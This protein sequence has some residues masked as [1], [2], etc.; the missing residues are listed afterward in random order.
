M[1][2]IGGESDEDEYSLLQNLKENYLFSYCHHLIEYN[3]CNFWVH[4][5]LTGFELFCLVSYLLFASTSYLSSTSGVLDMEI[6]PQLP[7]T[8]SIPYACV[9][10]Y[11]AAVGSLTLLTAGFFLQRFVKETDNKCSGKVAGL[12]LKVL[13]MLIVALGTCSGSISAAMLLVPFQCDLARQNSF[14]SGNCLGTEHILLMICSGLFSLL[15]IVFQLIYSLFIQ[16]DF[17]HSTHMY[18]GLQPSWKLMG[19]FFKLVIAFQVVFDSSYET[20]P[21]VVAVILLAHCVRIYIS[22]TGPPMWN[23][24]FTYLFL[25]ADTVGCFISAVCLAVTLTEYSLSSREAII[26]FIMSCFFGALVVLVKHRINDFYVTAGI[27]DLN[28]TNKCM[29][30]LHMVMYMYLRSGKSEECKNKLMGALAN[31]QEQCEDDDCKC[32]EVQ[33]LTGGKGFGRDNRSSDTNSPRQAGRM[34]NRYDEIATNRQDPEEAALHS[35][36][37][38]VDPAASII[39]ELILGIRRKYPRNVAFNLLESY[40]T[41]GMLQNSYKA[42]YEL[43]VSTSLRPDV[44]SSFAI[45]RYQ[46][47]IERDIRLLSTRAANSFSGTSDI[48]VESAITMEQLYNIFRNLMLETAKDVLQFLHCIV[49]AHLN[50]EKLEAIASVIGVR[51]VEI[52]KTFDAFYKEY[53][54][55]Y[56]ALFEYGEYLEFILNCEIEAGQLSNKAQS[57]RGIIREKRGV[58]V[59]E[60]NLLDL[61]RNENVAVFVV[62]A[63]VGKVGTILNCN[64][65]VLT[66][67]GY[68]AKDVLDQN[69]N[70]LIPS[71]F[72]EVHSELMLHLLN[73]GQM[74]SKIASQRMVGICRDAKGYLHYYDLFLQLYPKLNKGLLFAVFAKKLE[75]FGRLLQLKGDINEQDVGVVTCSPQGVILGISEYMTKS[76]GIPNSLIIQSPANPSSER[77]KCTI[78]DLIPEFDFNDQDACTG[79]KIMAVSGKGLEKLIEVESY[80][81][82]HLSKMYERF[83]HVSQSYIYCKLRT[84]P[85]LK[86]YEILIMRSEEDVWESPVGSGEK[87]KLMCAEGLFKD[88]LQSVTTSSSNDSVRKYMP[89]VKNIKENMK[90]ESSYKIK[91]LQRVATLLCLILFALNTTVMVF[92]I[93]NTSTN[94]DRVL[95]YDYAW[96]RVISLSNIHLIMKSLVNIGKG[97]ESEAVHS[98]EADTNR[99]DNLKASLTKNLAQLQA[100]QNSFGK[101]VTSFS[102][103]LDSYSAQGEITVSLI[104]SSGTVRADTKSSSGSFAELVGYVIEFNNMTLQDFNSSIR[105]SNF[106]DLVGK[107]LTAKEQVYYFVN[108][109]TLN[110]YRAFCS[111]FCDIFQS[112]AIKEASRQFTTIIIFCSISLLFILCSGLLLAFIINKIKYTKLIVLAFYAEIPKTIIKNMLESVGTFVAHLSKVKSEEDA[113]LA[114]KARHKLTQTTPGNV[115]KRAGQKLRFVFDEPPPKAA[116]QEEEAKS[117][118]EGDKTADL[119]KDEAAGKPVKVEDD[120]AQ[121]KKQVADLKKAVPETQE[122]REEKETAELFTTNK[123]DNTI[124]SQFGK[125]IRS[126]RMAVIILLVLFEMLFGGYTVSSIIFYWQSSSATSDSFN[127][128]SAYSGFHA[129]Y[130]YH[131][132]VYSRFLNTQGSSGSL[133]WIAAIIPVMATRITGYNNLKLLDSSLL[134]GDVVRYQNFVDTPTGMCEIYAA[135]GGDYSVCNADFDGL[136]QLGFTSIVQRTIDEIWMQYYTY[137]VLLT[138][139]GFSSFLNRYTD[140]QRVKEEYMNIATSAV[141]SKLTVTL[142]HY[143]NYLSTLIILVYVAWLVTTLIIYVWAMWYFVKSLS[144]EVLRSNG[145]LHILPTKYLVVVVQTEA[146]RLFL[147]NSYL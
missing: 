62:S 91:L 136:L 68:E 52:A 43:V 66:N 101:S 60:T 86:L 121:Q 125:S 104:D 17:F 50:A 47:L 67:F 139:Y 23:V 144:K 85:G 145:V 51:N 56:Q 128:L 106:D 4:L 118:S 79:R 41:D 24:G 38:A 81:S 77:Q 143:F 19:T 31:H 39:H 97:I 119:S 64:D 40:F 36:K 138:N 55:H 63:N 20:V 16:D 127:Y 78:N 83:A 115:T 42:V 25:F 80:T 107:T 137:T 103:D 44:V 147:K 130:T 30:Y 84:Y 116:D 53:P 124:R 88:E 69:I 12:V 94:M 34:G 74:E 112:A 96:I 140:L 132:A 28:S 109:N 113:E 117:G 9:C 134:I 95:T 105:S 99:F 58:S 57:I 48:S 146:G 102:S 82:E 11:Y 27:S 93:N 3:I 76:F 123:L 26:A 108:Y 29:Y 15:W 75:R 59:N 133:G 61:A 110:T 18:A 131:M 92:T 120:I 45:Y 7:M 114:E 71:Y 70:M 98:D 13:G 142:Q 14:F 87:V 89:L 33:L 2:K 73:Y 37:N 65:A 10:L 21:I 126:Q 111:S 5:L 141:R 72:Q 90:S 32:Q 1:E 122:D 8:A 35:L 49:E 135:Q 6:G 54:N 46:T 129:T 100:L 22:L